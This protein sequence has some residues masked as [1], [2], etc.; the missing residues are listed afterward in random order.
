METFS[1][2]SLTSNLLD[3]IDS[4]PGSYFSNIHTHFLQSHWSFKSGK[5]GDNSLFIR[6]STPFRT[7]LSR[8]K[9]SLFRLYGHF[10]S[11]VLKTFQTSCAISELLV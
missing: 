6:T 1:V 7:A 2:E 10:R 8:A 4:C 11:L 3:C 5:F 9:E